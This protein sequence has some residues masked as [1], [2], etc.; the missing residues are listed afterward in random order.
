MS[1]SHSPEHSRSPDGARKIPPALNYVLKWRRPPSNR[2]N[3]C[4]V[5]LRCAFDLR[6]ICDRPALFRMHP[7]LWTSSKNPYLSSYMAGCVAFRLFVLGKAPNDQTVNSKHLFQQK[8]QLYG[9]L[10]VVMVTVAYTVRISGYHK[11]IK[12]RY[13]CYLS[14]TTTFNPLYYVLSRAYG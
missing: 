8:S 13:V 9:A 12:C 14:T 4:E 5:R 6:T 11:P 1:I 10:L 3:V 2:R 7:R